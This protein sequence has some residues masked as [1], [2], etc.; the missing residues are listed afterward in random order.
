MARRSLSC[1]LGVDHRAAL[2][3]S[4][5]AIEALGWDL[6][7]TDSALVGYED[8]ARLCCHD[9][10]VRVSIAVVQSDAEASVLNI[11]ATVP[12]FG[13]IASRSLKSRLRAI[14]GKIREFS[15]APGGGAT[16]PY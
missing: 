12:G 6:E 7:S 16:A 14:E 4:A 2:A 15:D 5:A 10:P 1:E 8:S 3:A 13:P 9:S 11:E